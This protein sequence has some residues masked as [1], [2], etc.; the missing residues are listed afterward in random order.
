MSADNATAEGIVSTAGVSSAV[1]DG[2]GGMV[3]HVLLLDADDADPLAAHRAVDGMEGVTALLESSAGSWHLWNLSVRPFDETTLSALSWQLADAQHVAQSYRR[4][5][6][7]LRWVAKVREDGTNY[8]ER[9]A[10]RRLE[11]DLSDETPPQS[12]PHLA[13]LNEVAREDPDAPDPVVV[14]ED[15]LVG[16]SDG[17]R[18]DRYQTLTDEVKREIREA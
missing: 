18:M 6:A 8:K 3:G 9:P 15:R 5:Y 11:V 2:E 4:G 12:R 16:A 13:A 1:G 10:L 14:P 17:L 7:V